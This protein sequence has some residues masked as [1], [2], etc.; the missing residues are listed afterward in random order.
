MIP[1]A[2]TVDRLRTSAQAKKLRLTPQRD[3]MLRILGTV[4]QHLTAY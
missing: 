4:R 1:A 2:E 3:L